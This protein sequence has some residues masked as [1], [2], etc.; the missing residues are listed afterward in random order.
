V[1]NA[2]AARAGVSLE[3]ADQ[4]GTALLSAGVQ[5][6]DVLGGVLDKFLDTAKAMNAAGRGADPTDTAKA[7]TMLMSAS[8]VDKDAAGFERFGRTMTGLFETNVELADLQTFAGKAGAIRQMTG[9]S[10]EEMAAAFAVL[11]ETMPAAE[12]ATG[13]KTFTQRLGPGK[14]RLQKRAISSLGLEEDQIDFVGESFEEVVKTLKDALARTDERTGKEAFKRIFGSEGVPAAA[15]FLADDDLPRYTQLTQGKKFEESAAFARGTLGS[16]Q[17]SAE[18]RQAAVQGEQGAA[19]VTMLANQR[20]AE[21]LERGDN[22]A[23]VAIARGIADFARTLVEFFDGP[24]MRGT[25]FDRIILEDP[26]TGAQRPARRAVQN[27]G[28]N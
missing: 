28:G 16:R 25:N 19:T 20:Q 4:A 8:G 18:A 13:F 7:A 17:T 11:R 12:A 14:T 10:M 27:L 22:P 26:T 9:Q 6:Q 21:M 24:M 23:G 1:L 2:S 15:A 5:T 3:Q